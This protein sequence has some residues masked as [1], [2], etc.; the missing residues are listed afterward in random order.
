[1]TPPPTAEP[2]GLDPGER[3][4][5]AVGVRAVGGAAQGSAAGHRLQRVGG[6]LRH[7]RRQPV[8]SQDE[9]RAS[10]KDTKLAQ[11]LGQLQPFVAAFPRECVGQL[12]SFGPT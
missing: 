8:R 7:D 9:P 2:G 1:M 10:E 4:V 5:A 12:A 3:D 6:L 11:K